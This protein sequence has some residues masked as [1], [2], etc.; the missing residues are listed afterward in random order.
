MDWEWAKQ[1]QVEWL[2]QDAEPLVP[3]PEWI[4]LRQQYRR[5]KLRD[6]H[7]NRWLVELKPLVV[8]QALV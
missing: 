8:M 6:Y 3:L 1:E 7:E 5:L 2:V 4:F